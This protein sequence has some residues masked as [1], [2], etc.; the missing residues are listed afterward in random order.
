M[1]NGILDEILQLL[2]GVVRSWEPTS[3]NGEGRMWK[4]EFKGGL[5]LKGLRSFMFDPNKEK[6]ILNSEKGDYCD[7]IEYDWK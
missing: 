4:G 1:A 7:D 6:I 2:R 5:G 3:E